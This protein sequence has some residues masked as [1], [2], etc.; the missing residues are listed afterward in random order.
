M[1]RAR[2][3]FRHPRPG[4]PGGKAGAKKTYPWGKRLRLDQRVA[5]GDIRE[6]LSKVQ[7]RKSLAGPDGRHPQVLRGLADGLVRPL[8]KGDTAA[9]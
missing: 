5:E 1:V 2:P 6:D 9:R 3:A 8:Q 4:T 7:V